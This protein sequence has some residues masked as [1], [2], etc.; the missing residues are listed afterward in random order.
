MLQGVTDCST[1]IIRHDCQQKKLY[2]AQEEVEIALGD[3]PSKGDGFTPRC[4]VGQHFWR[5]DRAEEDERLHRR[6]SMGVWRR[7]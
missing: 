3:T 1:A 7:E 5:N 6:K 2:G 4:Y